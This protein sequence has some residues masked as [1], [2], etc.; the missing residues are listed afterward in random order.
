MNNNRHQLTSNQVLRDTLLGVQEKNADNVGGKGEKRTQLCE[1]C[2]RTFLSPRARSSHITRIHKDESQPGG[3]EK[4]LRKQQAESTCQEAQAEKVNELPV[5]EQQVN[6]SPQ[7]KHICPYCNLYI[8]GDVIKHIRSNC[9]KNPDL[10]PLE[11][12]RR[13]DKLK[14]KRLKSKRLKKEKLKRKEHLSSNRSSLEV[15][16]NWSSNQSQA[17]TKSSDKSL[18]PDLNGPE[19]A[20]RVEKRLAILESSLRVSVG[21]Q[22]EKLRQKTELVKSKLR[23]YYFLAQLQPLSKSPQAFAAFIENY[24]KQRSNVASIISRD[25]VKEN[26]QQISPIVEEKQ[27]PNGSRVPMDGHQ[28]APKNYEVQPCVVPTNNQALIVQHALGVKFGEGGGSVARGNDISVIQE[29]HRRAGVAASQKKTVGGKY[30]IVYKL[31]D[32]CWDRFCKWRAHR[33]NSEGNL[34]ELE[35]GTGAIVDTTNYRDRTISIS[36]NQGSVKTLVATLRLILKGKFRSL[37][38]SAPILDMYSE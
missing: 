12:E 30:K 26:W 6:E 38:S 10:D 25:I 22:R 18:I 34:R 4:K 24:R 35:K 14:R 20:K 3:S 21:E 15:S 1:Y 7:G 16:I 27:D 11:V 8:S 2:G 17:L 31:S 36:G 9:P 19:V 33:K 13:E 37:N 5:L 28:Q 29:V 23:R 32:E